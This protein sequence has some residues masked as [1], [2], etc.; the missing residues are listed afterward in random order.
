MITFKITILTLNQYLTTQFEHR[1]R[2]LHTHT[3]NDTLISFQHMIQVRNVANGQL[4]DLDL[5]QFLVRRQR[6]QQLAQLRERHIERLHADALARRV[7]RA[8]LLRGAAPSAALLSRQSDQIAGVQMGGAQRQHAA[9]PMRGRRRRHRLLV[10][11]GNAGVAGAGATV[12]CVFAAAA[13][14]GAVAVAEAQTESE[15][16]FVTEGGRRPV[17]GH[18]VLHV[19][20]HVAAAGGAVEVLVLLRLLLRTSCS[21]A[22]LR[23]LIEKWGAFMNTI[24]VL[25][26]SARLT[27]FW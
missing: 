15:E 3:N 2:I 9:P 1:L 4:Q 8:I 17:V 11:R 27:R 13:A 26:R 5:G 22:E 10:V 6:R 14:A 16:R 18:Q 20:H 25:T 23:S 21:S 12:R 24:M 19:V 7:R